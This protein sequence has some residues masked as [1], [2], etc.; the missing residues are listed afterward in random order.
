ME[1]TG[2][3]SMLSVV[4]RKLFAYQCTPLGKKKDFAKTEKESNSNFV[5]FK[6]SVLQHIIYCLFRPFL[7]VNI[8]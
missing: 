6:N 7:L 5:Q 8:Y 1:L 4:G 3:M 2:S